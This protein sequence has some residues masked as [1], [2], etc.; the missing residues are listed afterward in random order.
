VPVSAVAVPV[1]EI[2]ATGPSLIGN[3]PNPCN[4]R[5]MIVFAMRTAEQVSLKIYDVRGNLVR[6]LVDE[7]RAAGRQETAWDGA[8]AAGRAVASGTYFARMT[9]ATETSTR[10]LTLVR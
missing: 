8:D 2:L 10:P 5:T 9:T 4:P 3:Y 1:E 6:D 7:I